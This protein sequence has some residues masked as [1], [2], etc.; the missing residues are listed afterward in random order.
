MTLQQTTFGAIYGLTASIAI[1]AAILPQLE[2]ERAV[3]FVNC[4]IKVLY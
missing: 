4:K 3:Y 1:V 2:N